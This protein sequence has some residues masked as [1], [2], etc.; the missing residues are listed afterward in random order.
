[1]DIIERLEFE[2]MHLAS[3]TTI[4]RTSSGFAIT[5]NASP[6]LNVEAVLALVDRI[7]A[8]GYLRVKDENSGLSTG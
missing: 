3:D 6:E 5:E 8:S 1:M 4:S 2:M 7:V